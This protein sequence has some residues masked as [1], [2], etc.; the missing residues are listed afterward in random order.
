MGAQFDMWTRWGRHF[1]SFNYTYLDTEEV[2]V[3]LPSGV[4]GKV[5]RGVM[6]CLDQSPRGAPHRTNSN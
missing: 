5:D 4:I 1:A 2:D 3:L 6:R